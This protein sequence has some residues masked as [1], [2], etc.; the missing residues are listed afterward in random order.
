MRSQKSDASVGGG[1]GRSVS[2]CQ[3]RPQGQG[4]IYPTGLGYSV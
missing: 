3:I 2:Q 4:R 1:E